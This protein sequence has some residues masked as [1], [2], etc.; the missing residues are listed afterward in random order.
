MVYQ[1]SHNWLN[2][3]MGLKPEDHDY[4]H[5]GKEAHRII[6]DHVSGK[7]IDDR[8]LHVKFNFPIVEEVDFDERCKFT[9]PFYETGLKNDYSMIGFMDGINNAEKRILEIK[10]SSVPWSVTKFQQLMQR[11]IYSLARTDL[12]ETIGI[13]GVMDPEQWKR[14]LVKVYKI[15]NTNK[16]RQ[17]AKAWI[18]GGI[19]II[20]SGDFKG[21]LNEDGK[22]TDPRCYYGVNCQFK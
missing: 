1:A 3:Q 4:Y 7:K 12:S 14:D 6:Q 17:E 2:K 21:G 16:D 15:P 19:K 13:T 8:L 9:M 18:L 20:E 5:K 10:I 11:K 22:C